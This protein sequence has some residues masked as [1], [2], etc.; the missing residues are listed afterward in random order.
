MLLGPSSRYSLFLSLVLLACNMTGV[1]VDAPTV[2]SGATD[3]FAAGGADSSMMKGGDSSQL[4]AAGFDATVLPE[5]ACRTQAD[6]TSLPCLAPGTFLGCGTCFKYEDEECAGDGDCDDGWICETPTCTCSGGKTCNLGCS[7]S[8][9]RSGES[10]S[11]VTHRCEAQACPCPKNF[12]CNGA[13]CARTACT[14]DA[15]CHGGVCVLSQCHD[16]F[17]TCTAPAA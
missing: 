17:G 2:D 7:D 10:C 5:H 8:S 9:C 12:S 11:T 3:A 4:D 13:T 15:D 1:G 16:D 6:C 14:S